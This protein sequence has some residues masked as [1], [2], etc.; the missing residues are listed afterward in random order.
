MGLTADAR[1]G[2]GLAP[3]RG[4]CKEKSSAPKR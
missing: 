1:T 4:I 2:E 3:G